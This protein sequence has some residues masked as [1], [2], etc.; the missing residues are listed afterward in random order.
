[1]TSEEFVKNAIRLIGMPY[2]TIDCIGVVRT[3]AG[4]KCQGTNWLWRSH[5]NSAKYRYL[6]ERYNFPPSKDEVI[7][8]LLVFRINW[9]QAPARYSDPP[10]CY[11]VGILTKNKTVIHSTQKYG[12][13]EE[14]YNPSQWQGYG[15][16]KQIDY[17]ALPAQPEEPDKEQPDVFTAFMA[18][19]QAITSICEE[20]EIIYN[21]ISNMKD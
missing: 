13:H 15:K 10:N 4:I 2:S 21:Y 14:D 1:M 7:D 6:T 8:G 16:L 18:I 3:A 9:N 17:S 19:D 5:E 12:V 20:L 11:H